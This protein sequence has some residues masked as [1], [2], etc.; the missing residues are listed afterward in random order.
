MSHNR[1]DQYN[2]LVTRLAAAAGTVADECSDEI[3]DT[4]LTREELQAIV[5]G[6]GQPRPGSFDESVATWSF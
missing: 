5:G 4:A 6:H 2:G 1:F 3:L